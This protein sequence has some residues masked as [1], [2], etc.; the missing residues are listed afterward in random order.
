VLDDL[1][2][3]WRAA[4]G[5]AVSVEDLDGT[6]EALRRLLPESTQVERLTTAIERLTGQRRR[7][8]SGASRDPRK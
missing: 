5:D 1:F 3:Q 6:E 2:A 4:V 8:L 7:T